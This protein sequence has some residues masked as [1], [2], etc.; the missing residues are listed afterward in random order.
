MSKR[1]KIAHQLL[2]DDGAIFISIDDAEHAR[3][4]LLCDEIFGNTNF[5]A[6]LVRKNK[7]GSGH[8]SKK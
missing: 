3:L 5:V 4:K 6:N 1:L 8:D 2:K 7:S